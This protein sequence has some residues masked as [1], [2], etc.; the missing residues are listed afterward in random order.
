MPVD[1]QPPLHLPRMFDGLPGSVVQRLL[2]AIRLRIQQVGRARDQLEGQV[3]IV[4]YLDQ[5][6]LMRQ[7]GEL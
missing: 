5:S 3:A 1:Y 2:A 4:I 7:L 6:A